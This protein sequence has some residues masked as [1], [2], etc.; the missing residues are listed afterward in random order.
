LLSSSITLKDKESLHSLNNEIR[1]LS[2]PAIIIINGEPPSE[3]WFRSRT[4]RDS[5]LSVRR[6]YNVTYVFKLPRHDL[7]NVLRNVQTLAKR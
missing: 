1:S 6:E 4:P 2:S 5:I 3:Y 7:R